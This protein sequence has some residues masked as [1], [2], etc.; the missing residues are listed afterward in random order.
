MERPWIRICP[1]DEPPGRED[2]RSDA[3]MFYLPASASTVRTHLRVGVPLD[4]GALRRHRPGSTRIS[5]ALACMC[6][7]ARSLQEGLLQPHRARPKCTLCYLRSSVG[8]PGPSA[9]DL[10]GPPALHGAALR[11]RTGVTRAVPYRAQREILLDP[12]DPQVVAQPRPTAFPTVI[13]VAQQ[14]PMKRR[15]KNETKT[16]A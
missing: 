16:R 6:V 10:R 8:Q 14:S 1:P 11:S 5:A 9:R 3:C 7:S 15:T 2:H 12:N 4:A 13:K